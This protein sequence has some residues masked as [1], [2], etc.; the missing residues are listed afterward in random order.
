[1]APL[2]AVFVAFL[3]LLRL[4]MEQAHRARSRV[5]LD[6]AVVGQ[7]NRELL[8]TV[9]KS[10]M[11]HNARAIRHTGDTLAGLESEGRG[12]GLR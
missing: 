8:S 5:D 3:S 9:D 4:L 1:M 12:L 2:Q 10:G 7:G 6:G 11:L